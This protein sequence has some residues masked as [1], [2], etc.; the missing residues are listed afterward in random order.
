MAP[1]HRRSGAETSES[2]GRRI[3]RDALPEQVLG[4]VR[5]LKLPPL[6][7][8]KAVTKALSSMQEPG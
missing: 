7:A 4:D 6:V 1:Q 8:D 3:L 2:I 5:C